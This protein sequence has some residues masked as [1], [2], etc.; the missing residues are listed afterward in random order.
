MIFITCRLE[1]VLY[2][3]SS[4]LRKKD[5]EK[6]DEITSEAEQDVLYAERVRIEKMELRF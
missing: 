4:S 1:R 2:S 6:D 5:P 3:R